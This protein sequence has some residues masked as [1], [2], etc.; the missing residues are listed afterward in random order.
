MEATGRSGKC[1]YSAKALF[2]AWTGSH[3]SR[4][5]GLRPCGSWTNRQAQEKAAGSLKLGRCTRSDA[6]QGDFRSPDEASEWTG[7]RLA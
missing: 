6:A 4:L 7:A 5:G 2:V 1:K 3:C